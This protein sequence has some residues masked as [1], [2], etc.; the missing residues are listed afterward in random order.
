MVN[1]RIHTWKFQKIMVNFRIRTR[2]Q[3]KIMVGSRIHAWKFQKIMVNLRIRTRKQLKIMVGSRI[4]AWKFQKIM[5]NFRILT[6]EVFNIKTTDLSCKAGSDVTWKFLTRCRDGPAGNDGC[7]NESA[8]WKLSSNV[9][10]SLFSWSILW[11][12]SRALSI[13]TSGWSWMSPNMLS[14]WK[15]QVNSSPA[16]SW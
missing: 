16:N 3:L 6:F 10:W 15:I 14:E 11:S 5:V 1:S 12:W 2:R 13:S 9:I 4:H 7:C 8:A